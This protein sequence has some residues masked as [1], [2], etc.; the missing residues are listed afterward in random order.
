VLRLDVGGTYTYDRAGNLDNNNA[1]DAGRFRVRRDGT[2]TFTSGSLSR[3]CA[4]GAVTKWRDVR[5]SG[6][7]LHAVIARDDCADSVG[8]ERTWILLSP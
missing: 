2:L 7:T 3:A 6:R 8:T 4:E 5:T 1:E